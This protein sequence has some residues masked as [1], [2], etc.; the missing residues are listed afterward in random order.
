MRLRAILSLIIIAACIGC[1][2][3]ERSFEQGA[4]TGGGGTGGSETGSG[5]KRPSIGQLGSSG[6]GAEAGNGEGASGAGSDEPSPDAEGGQSAGVAPSGDAGAPNE[7][8]AAGAGGSAEPTPEPFSCGDPLPAV[9]FPTVLTSSAT[10]PQP[11]GGNLTDGVYVL[12]QVVVYGTYSSVPGDVFELRGGYLHHQHTTYSSAGSAL[13][14]Y[15]EVGSYASTGAAMA[16]DVSACGLGT[17]LSLWKFTATGDRIQLFD[18][19]SSTTWVQ[20]FTRQP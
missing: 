20:T 7:A 4:G 16:V 1:A 10:P 18:T 15:E 13:T 6:S 8:G 3:T 2:A 12:E 11:A 19:S 5:G 9:S 14:G 17:G